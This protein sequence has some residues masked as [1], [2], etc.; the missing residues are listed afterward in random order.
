[1][2]PNYWTKLLSFLLQ[3][4]ENLKI[5][6]IFQ[7]KYSDS[8]SNFGR[9]ILIQVGLTKNTIFTLYK[10]DFFFAFKNI[11]TLLLTVQSKQHW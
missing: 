1:M 10:K 8:N 3:H 7:N 9:A 2:A 6:E 11:Q 5:L 4:E